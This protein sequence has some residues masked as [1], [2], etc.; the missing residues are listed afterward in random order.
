MFK[1]TPNTKIVDI[2]QEEHLIVSVLLR[3]EILPGYGDKTI[4]Q[5][6]DET[7][8][9][10]TFLTFLISLYLNNNL[11]T[12]EEYKNIDI[13]LITSFLQKSHNFYKEEKIPQL[14]QVFNNMIQQAKAE[15]N[16]KVLQYYFDN[17]LNEFFIHME[18]EEKQVFPYAEELSNILQNHTIS[19][20]F[21][22]GFNTFSVQS[23][24]EQ[25]EEGTQEKLEDL[26]NILLKFVPP[27]NSYKEYYDVIDMLFSLGKDLNTHM[28]IENNILVPQLSNM[29]EN[30]KKLLKENKITLQP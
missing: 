24:L 16:I 27:L 7:N 1:I 3:L 22:E 8:Y 26:K 17:Y 28:I 18:Y 13:E 6:A 20:K 11:E 25:H 14:K 19:K 30:V 2:I 15:T 21:L 23:Y 9:D 10:T 29:G 5:I 4:Q 12:S